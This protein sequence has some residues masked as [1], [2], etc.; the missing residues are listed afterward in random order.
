MSDRQERLDN[1]LFKP[2]DSEDALNESPQNIEIRF[3]ALASDGRGVN[4]WCKCRDYLHDFYRLPFCGM[5]T[6]VYGMKYN[7]KDNPMVDVSSLSL[8]VK[9]GHMEGNQHSS[10]FLLNMFEDL[11]GIKEK[12]IL[13]IKNVGF[14]DKKEYSIFRG[15]DEWLSNSHLIS[16]YSFLIRLGCYSSDKN[17]GDF[18]DDIHSFKKWVKSNEGRCTDFN[19]LQSCIDKG[20]LEVLVN[21]R[22]TFP[23]KAEFWENA[24]KIKDIYA[25]HN[26]FGFQTF[27]K[28][29]GHHA[30]MLELDYMNCFYQHK[31][32]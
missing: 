3:Q 14:F 11:M 25:F 21:W 13:S 2:F 8:A 18:P 6:S 22:E 9:G 16:L 29:P 30:E 5:S 23:K 20:L 15:S 4:T 10:L 24:K 1:L 32:T 7:K 12:S 26:S 31:V 27:I 19:R 17:A 28:F